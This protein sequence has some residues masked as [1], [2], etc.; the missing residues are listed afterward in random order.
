M[1]PNIYLPINWTDGVKLTKDHFINN[2]FNFIT[3]VSDHNKV[4]LNNFNYGCIQTAK[5]KSIDI[6]I[7]IEGGQL[8]AYLKK[9]KL[10][11]KNGHIISF[12]QDI[13][14]TKLP[15]ASINANDLDRNSFEHYYV[16][17]SINP[18]DLI[19]VGIPDPEMIPLHHPHV[20]PEIKLHIVNKK[21]VNDNFLEGYFLIAK[22]IAFQNGTFIEDDKYIAPVVKTKNNEILNQFISKVNNELYLLN[23]FSVKM[24]KKNSHSSANNRLVANTFN[25][26]T[27]IID[28]YAEHCFYLK[29]IAS[30]EA[31]VYM[32]DKIIV[33]SNQLLSTL[34]LMDDKEKEVL[35]QYYYEW[36]DVKPSELLNVLFE[37]KSAVYDHNDI[38]QTLDKLNQF[39]GVLKRL[40]QKLS[41]LEYIGVRKENIVISEET[42]TLPQRSN[43]WS[44]LD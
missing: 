14:G 19:P 15:E 27:K 28:Y 26:C 35:L 16:I 12:D 40:W 10:I 23:D 31:P 1:K 33:L 21:E 29:N 24:H 41:E 44:I 38:T 25:L 37:A 3:I 4:Q 18:Y 39:L 7:K 30:E 13:Y 11:A 2:Y 20:L 8:V 9:C 5:E 22:K 42:K 32:F 6:D 36:I 17:V 43:T 34:T